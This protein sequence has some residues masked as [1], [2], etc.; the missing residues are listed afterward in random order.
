MR[1]QAHAE[2][3]LA[4]LGQGCDEENTLILKAGFAAPPVCS[5][6][7]LTDQSAET[8][9]RNIERTMKQHNHFRVDRF[10]FQNSKQASFNVKM[11]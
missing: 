1:P 11:L 6:L 10:P 4:Y 5:G 9:H 3:R 8:I 2:G 7:K